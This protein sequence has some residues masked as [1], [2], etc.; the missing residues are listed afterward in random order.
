MNKEK[1]KKIMVPLGVIKQLAEKFGC[2][3]MTVR[4]ALRGDVTSE[5][6]QQ[7]RDAAYNEFGGVYSRV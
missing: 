2:N 4:L 3:P 5:L 1:Q 6:R 7:I